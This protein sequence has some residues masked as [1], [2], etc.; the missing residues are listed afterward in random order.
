MILN[1]RGFYATM[2]WQNWYKILKEQVWVILGV[3][4]CPPKGMGQE[5]YKMKRKKGTVP[6]GTIPTEALMP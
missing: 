5:K 1:D 2:Q 6:L 3:F 4:S